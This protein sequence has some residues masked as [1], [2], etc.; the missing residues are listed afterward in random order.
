MK[1]IEIDIQCQSCRGTGVY[2]GMSE[3][4]G[5]AVVCNTCN[6]T[7]K[8]HYKF[9]FE[10]F[11]GLQIRENVKRVYKQSYG[12]VIAPRKIRFENDELIDMEKE[13]VSYEDFNNGKMPEHIKQFVCPMLADQGKC[14]NIKNF[15]TECEIA[16]GGSLFGVLLSNCKNQSNKL[17]CWER[18][19]NGIKINK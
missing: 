2:V 3:R 7:G 13:G 11:T 5:A 8:Y 4:D 17:K 6:G 9:E 12:Y 1:K 16:N 19:D 15:V 10:E 18:F 14:N